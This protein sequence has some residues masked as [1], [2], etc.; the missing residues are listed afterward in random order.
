M[1]SSLARTVAL[2]AA[3][4]AGLSASLIAVPAQA[5]DAAPSERAAA[6]RFGYKANIFG[7]KVLVN[8]VEV[9]T[10]RDA[11]LQMP[12]TR[13]VGV[14]RTVSSLA[15]LPIDNEL[16]K[17]AATTS[18]SKT[19]AANGINGVRAISTVADIELGGKLGG[20][21][22]PVLKIKGLESVADSF[23]DAKAAGGKGAFRSTSSF[24]YQGLTLDL[25]EDSPISETLDT[26]FD[27]L[28]IP[29]DQVFDVVNV[30]V[31][32]LVD[33]LSSVGTITIPQLGAITLGTENTRRGTN[34]ANAEAYAL[35]VLVDATGEDTVLQLGRAS[36]R[37]SRPVPAGVFRSTMSALELNALDNLVSLGGISQRSIPCEGTFGKLRTVT[38]G[39]ASLIHEELGV[40]VKGIKYLYK[41]L[42]KGATGRGFTA[43][44]LGEVRVA[45]PGTLDILIKGLSSRVD[46][47]APG[48]GK[49]VRKKVSTTFA[50][51][52]VNG[53]DITKTLRPGSGYR[54]DNGVVRMLVQRDRNYY[55]TMLSGLVIQLT[56]LDTAIRL[57]E[58]SARFLT[59]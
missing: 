22:T 2:A 48:K 36:S 45:V 41:G 13:M 7:T 11:N 18:R 38:T 33:V 21:P 3:C 52:F 1:R 8:N 23:Y 51:I 5:E 29:A 27:A 57:G 58:V 10:L 32:T 55:G 25:P 28:G 19:Y 44:Q 9:H 40:S 30:P 12:C 16:I 35:K 6:S 47:F 4:A 26:L 39:T 54:F 43:A 53:V 50:Q 56:Q 17:V 37:I 46:V 31:A 14:E 42:Q 20:V 15:S 49:E 34:F 24:G 59:K